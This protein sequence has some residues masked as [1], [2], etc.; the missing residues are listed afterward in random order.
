MT[1]RINPWFRVPP[2]LKEMVEKNQDWEI[3]GRGETIEV[4]EETEK[5]IADELMGAYF[6][7]V[8]DM[9]DAGIITTSDFDLVIA[10][11][12]DMKPP[13]TYMNKIGVDKA[14][15]LVE[16]FAKKYPDMPVSKTLKE[17]AASGEP[18][19]L[20][21]VIFEKKGDIG[22][23]TIRRPRA[24]NALNSKVFKELKSY[25][26]IIKSDPEI[27]AAVLT[28][29]GKRAFVAG[30]DIKEM[31]GFTS[32]EQG[33]AFARVGQIASLELQTMGKPLVAAINGLA[34]GGGCEIAMSCNARVAPKGLGFFS[35]QPEVNIGLI[36]GMGGTVRLPRLVGFEK[37][38]EMIRTANPISSETALEIGLV[39]EL[40]EG[41]VLERA[42]E[43]GREMAD[44]KS[45]IKPMEMG[46]LSDAPDSLPHI[47][48][49][50]HSK[51]LDKFCVASILEGGKMSLDDALKNE[52][53]WFGQCW[54]TEDNKIGL[55]TFVEKGARAKAEFI[56]K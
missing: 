39:D 50:H 33:E 41:D 48:I 52:A 12:L 9:L 40:V 56:H 15:E 3:P 19:E 51:A 20:L 8:C 5:A 31:S 22:V 26:E 24:L 54:T 17:Q 13:F 47:D 37:A 28:G 14:L 44:G 55:T 2:R 11:A 29:H 1:E 35:G 36:P 34:L 6:A 10:T 45:N 7:I 53:K 49:G 23:M 27:K 42:M 38:S 30:A 16:N 25:M 4:A 46:P 43:L 21:D 18:W 32:P